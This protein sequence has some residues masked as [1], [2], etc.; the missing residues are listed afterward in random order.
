MFERFDCCV[1]VD[2][3]DTG[4]VDAGGVGMDDIDT[5]ET[6]TEGCCF[7]GGEVETVGCLWTI[8]DLGDTDEGVVGGVATGVGG[9]IGVILGAIDVC[10]FNEGEEEEKGAFCSVGWFDVEF[11]IF[12]KGV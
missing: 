2:F 3:G 10:F 9:T 5:G 8:V 11:S 12:F 4:D 1:D 7:F 6:D